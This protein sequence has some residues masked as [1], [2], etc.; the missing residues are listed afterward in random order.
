MRYQGMADTFGQL[1]PDSVSDVI[2]SRRS[3]M[4]RIVRPRT[5]DLC[6]SL[7]AFTSLTK[8]TDRDRARPTAVI[9]GRSHGVRIGATRDL[10]TV[11][12]GVPVASSAWRVGEY[13]VHSR[14]R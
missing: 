11:E 5:F 8:Q 6:S 2:L 13:N 12:S 9:R 4:N 10:S 14:D 7:I 1:F 3:R